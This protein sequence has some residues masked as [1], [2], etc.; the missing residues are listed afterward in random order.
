MADIDDV[1]RDWDADFFDELDDQP[2]V[3]LGLPMSGEHMQ[4]MRAF[5]DAST[6]QL[7]FF[8]S[9]KTDL[10]K[11]LS[12][13][14]SG[15]MVCFIGKGHDY[16]ACIHGHLAI[17]PE[18]E[19]ERIVAKHWSPMI[20]AW[21]EGGKDDPYLCVLSFQ[22]GHAAV[23]ASTGNPLKFGWEMAKAAVTS[24]TPDLGARRDV[25]FGA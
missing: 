19:A 3:L 18:P 14:S 5:C 9:R 1:K 6:R 2:V 21:F 13:G 8:T 23:W 24:D 20:G 12:G 22:L 7:H 16:H 15:G 10:A 25:Q 11:E 17:V 4:P